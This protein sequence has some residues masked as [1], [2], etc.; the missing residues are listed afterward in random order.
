VKVAFLTLD[1]VIALHADQIERYGGRP[2]IRDLGLLQSALGTPSA[3]FEGRFLHEDLQ[4]MAAAHLFHIV[5]NHPFVDGNKRVG[6]MV[7]LA[8][9]GLNS[10]RLDA[11]ARE[12]EDLVLGIARGRVSKAEA[13]VFVQ[14]H[15]RPRS[16]K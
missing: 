9:L 1:E 15:L 7:L 4:E 16:E 13:A 14:Q 5:R 3:T 2:G 12:V 11:N 10:R 6:L 8:F